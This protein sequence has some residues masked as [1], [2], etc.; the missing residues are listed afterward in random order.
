MEM[1]SNDAQHIV[2]SAE[3]LTPEETHVR[4]KELEAW[5]VDLTLIRAGL[6]LTPTERIERMIGLLELTEE[7][8]RGYASKLS[9]GHPKD[10]FLIP[11]I[12]AVLKLHEQE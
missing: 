11:Q 8:Q 1:N 3:P 5:G 12:E 2:G 10:L 7:L 9:F 4:L 6:Q